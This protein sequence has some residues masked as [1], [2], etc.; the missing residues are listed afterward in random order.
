MFGGDTTLASTTPSMNHAQTLACN[1]LNMSKSDFEDLM[2][3]VDVSRQRSKE[4]DE[5]DERKIRDE[6][7]DQNWKKSVEKMA[8]ENVSRK[9][10]TACFCD[11]IMRNILL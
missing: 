10:K 8:T 5:F 2:T 6:N 9:Y 11:V 4:K 3:P 1:I 7:N